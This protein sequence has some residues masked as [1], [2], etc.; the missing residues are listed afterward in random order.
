[1]SSRTKV[2]VCS[3]PCL[4]L[5]A[6]PGL[7]QTELAQRIHVSFPRINE[8]VNGKRGVTPDTAEALSTIEPV[9]A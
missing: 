1:M 6:L 4:K 3:A 2:T 7:R 9:S 5:T 8:I